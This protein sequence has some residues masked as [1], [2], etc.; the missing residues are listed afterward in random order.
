MQR[1][2][3]PGNYRNK[4]LIIINKMYARF[5]VIIAFDFIND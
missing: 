2:C 1:A 5:T 4:F 3:T